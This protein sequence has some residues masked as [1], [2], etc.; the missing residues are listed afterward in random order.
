[1]SSAKGANKGGA[2]ARPT[3]NG[4]SD[5]ATVAAAAV[6]VQTEPGKTCKGFIFHYFS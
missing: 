3:K 2:K 6:A 4:T 5:A 1:M